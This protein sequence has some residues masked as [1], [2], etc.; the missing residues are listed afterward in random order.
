MISITSDAA[1]VCRESIRQLSILANAKLLRLRR[2]CGRASIALEIP[3]RGDDIV[4]HEGIPVLAVP[5][6][7]A[8]EL[9]SMTLDV[10]DEGVFVIA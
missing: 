9:T 5:N 7:V 3:Q 1:R 2:D 4:F 8:K 10:S 6:D